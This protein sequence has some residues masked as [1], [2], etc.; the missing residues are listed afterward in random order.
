MHSSQAFAVGSL[1]R[2][3]AFE[4]SDDALQSIPWA[5]KRKLDLA[6]VRLP[7]ESWRALPWHERLALCEIPA[8][9]DD[10]IAS[11][12]MVLEGFS[13]G[14]GV[15][16]QPVPP[17]VLPPWRSKDVPVTLTRRLAALRIAVMHARWQALDDLERYALC[18]LAEKRDASRLFAA[19]AELGLLGPAPRERAEVLSPAGGAPG[20]Y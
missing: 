9:S 17:I 1:V 3:F 19:L 5:V 4:G 20:E 2:R 7:P 10:E 6:A 16:T 18:R 8:E 13:R 15:S 12:R 11:F 14:R